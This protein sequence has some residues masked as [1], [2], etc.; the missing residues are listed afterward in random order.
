MRLIITQIKWW[1]IYWLSEK[2]GPNKLGTLA[3]T[4]LPRVNSNIEIM[5][6]IIQN[7]KFA[8][9]KLIPGIKDKNLEIIE[10]AKTEI[11]SAVKEGI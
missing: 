11:T 3:E 9:E 1:I 6:E 7:M 5:N 2:T 10:G 4:V 8:F